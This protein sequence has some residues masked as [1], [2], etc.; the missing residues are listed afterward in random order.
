MPHK[1]A[2]SDN[3]PE[4]DAPADP[5]PL[6]N[7][8]HTWSLLLLLAIIT[9]FGHF[10]APAIKVARSRSAEYLASIVLE[11]LLFGFVIVGIR[12]RRAF[13]RSAF[14]AK[15]AGWGQAFGIGCITYLAGNLAVALVS[16][17][18]YFTP[19]FHHRNT[20]VVLALL[21]H[22]PLEFTLWFAVSLSAGMTEEMIFRG[23][24]QQQFTAW[25][26]RPLLAI[27]LASIVFGS[28]HLYEGLGAI[29][30]LVALA[31]V[32]GNVVRWMKGDLRA[33]IVAHTLQDFLIALVVFVK[34]FMDQYAPHA[35]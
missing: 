9:A 11:W 18:L 22:T 16:A 8:W 19:L 6:A 34:P 10:H 14:E 4:S 7:A 26:K 17:S 25:I 28:A 3:G 30:P 32:Y 24:L 29:L 27:V 21:P 13:L 20:A 12:R 33:V 23:Y 2:G 35:H 5:Q 1:E 15:R 31:F